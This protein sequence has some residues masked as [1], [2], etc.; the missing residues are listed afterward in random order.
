MGDQEYISPGWKIAV[1]VI[2]TITLT[3]VVVCGFIV[4]HGLLGMTVFGSLIGAVLLGLADLR[5]SKSLHLHRV[6]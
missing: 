5:M 6:S 4:C 2:D 3:F 1:H